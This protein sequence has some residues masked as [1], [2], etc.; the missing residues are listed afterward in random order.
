[1]NKPGAYRIGVDIGGTF[2]DI[3]AFNDP[4]GS[5]GMHL[6]DVFVVKP[7]FVDDVIVGYAG[8]LGHQSDIGGIAPGSMALYATEIYQEGLRI[9][10]MKHYDAGEISETIGVPTIELVARLAHNTRRVY[11]E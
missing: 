11:I 4:Y 8:A 9:P 5:G 6:P 2:T 3:V 10:L 7:V 1:M